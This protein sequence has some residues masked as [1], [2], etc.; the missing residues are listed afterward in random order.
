MGG[1]LYYEVGAA[2]LRSQARW[3]VSGRVGEAPGSEFTEK[4]SMAPHCQT[5]KSKFSRLLS[6]CCFPDQFNS[7]LSYPCG[8]PLPNH[9]LLAPGHSGH[10]P[11]LC[12][13]SLSHCSTC[14]V[15]QKH[16][17]LQEAFP[18]YASSSISASTTPG[19]HLSNSFTWVLLMEATDWLPAGT[20]LC[21][22]SA[23]AQTRLF[24]LSRPR[25]TSLY[26]HAAA[27]C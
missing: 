8:R 20:T 27:S 13:N 5:T 2:C 14:K 26:C 16:H 15:E 10:F 12:P 23:R 7:L 18:D 3:G 21:T 19:K 17:L 6:L 4:A 9:H 25:N 24:P 1:S 22:F 11:N